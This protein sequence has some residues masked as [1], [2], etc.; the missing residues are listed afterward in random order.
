MKEKE[1][2]KM[3]K[4]VEK[5]MKVE[6]VPETLYKLIDFTEEE[7]EFIGEYEDEFYNAL[8]E[9]LWKLGMK[10]D[11]HSDENFLTWVQNGYIYVTT[12]L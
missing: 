2:K 12:A 5:V 10:V 7:E 3:T 9:R 11:D 6:A 8:N 4:L 1:L